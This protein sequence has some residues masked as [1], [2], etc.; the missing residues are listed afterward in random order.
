MLPFKFLG[1]RR[2]YP[3]LPCCFIS[4]LHEKRKKK[5]VEY[6]EMKKKKSPKEVVLLKA[7]FKRNTSILDYSIYFLDSRP[8]HNDHCLWL[9]R[10][11]EFVVN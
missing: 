8:E 11:K 3:L 9:Q 6:F 10:V 1:E 4:Y 5:I 2:T 7:E